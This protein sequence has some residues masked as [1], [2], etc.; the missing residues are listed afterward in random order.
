MLGTVL[1]ALKVGPG[2]SFAAFGAGAVGLSAVMAADAAGATTIF[3]IDIVPSRLELAR[4][5]GATHTVD[6]SEDDPVETVRAVTG[7]GVDYAMD[8]TGTTAVIRNAVL[9]LLPTGFAAI[10]G[11]SKP[12]AVLDLDVND[13]M[14]SAKSIRG[15]VE[16]DSVP[17][18]FIPKLIDLYL[19]GRIPF[20]K[21]VKFYAFDDINEAAGCAPSAP[22][23]TAYKPDR[24]HAGRW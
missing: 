1:N 5:L 24:T 21:L 22:I 23:S 12:G 8:S 16:G 17:D 10:V 3:A 20:D 6:S 14:Q 13:L 9:A 19:A 15:V 7:K 11:A 4:D 2:A 18:V